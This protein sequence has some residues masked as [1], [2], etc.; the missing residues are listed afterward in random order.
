MASATR[1]VAQHP[2]WRWTVTCEE[3]LTQTANAAGAEVL[4]DAITFIVTVIV[5][6]RL[7]RWAKKPMDKRQLY[8]ENFD[9]FDMLFGRVLKWAFFGVALIVSVSVFSTVFSDINTAAHPVTSSDAKFYCSDNAPDVL[10][11]N[12]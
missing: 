10:E 11:S 8:R 6:W 4:P 1:V 9:D 5:A 7:L 2:E 12:Q 3:F